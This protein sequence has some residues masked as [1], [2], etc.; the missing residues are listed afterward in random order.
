MSN[1]EMNDGGPAFPV[2][3]DVA[4]FTG[5][6]RDGVGYEKAHPGISTRDWF[7][8]MALST[9]N[10]EIYNGHGWENAIAHHAFKIADA[11]LD[12]RGKERA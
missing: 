9:I 10:A 11:M 4:V 7:A 12:E 3:A 8:G 5:D 1:T 6:P 2:P